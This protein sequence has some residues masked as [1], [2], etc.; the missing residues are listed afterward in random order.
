MKPRYNIDYVGLFRYLSKMDRSEVQGCFVEPENPK[1]V[2]GVMQSDV[3]FFNSPH[4]HDIGYG[5]PFL[6]DLLG[7]DLSIGIH[8]R[9]KYKLPTGRAVHAIFD[10][11]IIQDCWLQYGT[12]LN[13]VWK[14]PSQFLTAIG[15]AEK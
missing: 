5:E 9:R 1:L 2:E 4:P 13:G 7:N 10:R 15:G 6:C 8:T 14:I 11:T 12:P 3:E